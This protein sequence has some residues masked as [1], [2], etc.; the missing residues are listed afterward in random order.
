[1]MSLFTNKNYNIIER[2]LQEILVSIIS[3]K[4]D[5]YLI[6]KAIHHFHDTKIKFITNYFDNVT[7]FD[8][9]VET[10]YRDHIIN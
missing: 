6:R 8:K 7:N 9:N 1:M 3:T 2:I 10:N 4:Y 5:L